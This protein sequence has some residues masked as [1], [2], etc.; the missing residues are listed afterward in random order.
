MED[1]TPGSIYAKESGIVK[2]YHVERGLVL[3]QEEVYVEKGTLLISGEL[4]HLDSTVENIRAKGY[5]IAEVE[6]SR[7]YDSESKSRNC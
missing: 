4:I 1:K 3:V 6:V 5:V 7:L 2:K